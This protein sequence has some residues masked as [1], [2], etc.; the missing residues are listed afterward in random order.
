[1]TASKPAAIRGR[2]SVRQ[3]YAAGDKSALPSARDHRFVH[4]G[5]I[6]ASQIVLP[7]MTA[8]ILLLGLTADEPQRQQPEGVPPDTLV[9][10]RLEP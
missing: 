4:L 2:R 7:P 3:G 1:L 6:P 8:R 10:L 5:G 9:D